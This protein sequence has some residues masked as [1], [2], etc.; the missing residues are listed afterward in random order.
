VCERPQ[1]SADAESIDTWPGVSSTLTMKPTQPNPTRLLPDDDDRE[2]GVTCDE[3]GDGFL[4][5]HQRELH[6]AEV[7]GEDAQHDQQRLDDI[8]GD[9]D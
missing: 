6:R 2:I 3:C 1:K 5:A 8:G 4:T 9:H 7:H